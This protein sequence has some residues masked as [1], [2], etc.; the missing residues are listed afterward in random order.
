MNDAG[1]GIPGRLGMGQGCQSGADEHIY[2]RSGLRS[3]ARS[4]HGAYDT[5]VAADG[6]RT[7]LPVRILPP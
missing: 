7:T 6:F 2:R 3:K 4:L 1:E 5:A